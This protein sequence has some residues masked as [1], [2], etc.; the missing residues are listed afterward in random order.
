MAA[1]KSTYIPGATGN[2]DSVPSSEP[3]SEAAHASSNRSPPESDHFSE[4]DPDRQETVISRR[5]P[6]V[7][8][9]I[10][11]SFDSSPVLEGETL[12]HFRLEKFVGGGGMGSVYRATDTM[13]DRTVAVKVLARDHSNEELLKRFRNEAQSGARLDHDNIARV[14]YVGEDKGLCYIVFEFNE[15][16]NIRDLVARRGP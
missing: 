3:A 12:G 16:Y 4:P 14:H 1:K 9:R 8:A 6:D 7:M 11:G 2:A 13:L 15:G 5:R 10:D